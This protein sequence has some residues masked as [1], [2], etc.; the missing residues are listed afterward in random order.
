MALKSQADFIHSKS[1]Y[2]DIV[3]KDSDI[4]I[5]VLD[6]IEAYKREGESMHH[7]VFS[8][9][10]YD[11]PDTIILSAHDRDGNR[12]ETIEY[13]LSLNKVVQSRGVCNTLSNQH[14]RIISLVNDNAYRFIKAKES[15]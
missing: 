10:Y 3:I 8:C 5:S 11:K 6:S 13:S 12:I 14:E 4:E 15:A 9:R 7:C 2:F 1:C